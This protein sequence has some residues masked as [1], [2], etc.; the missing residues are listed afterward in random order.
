[1]VRAVLF[2]IKSMASS[3][4]WMAFIS[5]FTC[6]SARI[7]LYNAPPLPGYRWAGAFA[8]IKKDFSCVGFIF[9]GRYA[10]VT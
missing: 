7:D 2:Q 1:V 6:G 4:V 3:R 9:S 8:K 5:S 10:A